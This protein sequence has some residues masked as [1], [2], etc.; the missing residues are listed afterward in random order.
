MRNEFANAFEFNQE[1]GIPESVCLR[2]L[3]NIGVDEVDKLRKYMGTPE[4]IG[5]PTT[6]REKDFE[7]E[8]LYA[9]DMSF[10]TEEDTDFVAF[11]FKNRTSLVTYFRKL[12][13][14]LCKMKLETFSVESYFAHIHDDKDLTR[15]GQLMIVIDNDGEN[16]LLSI[17]SDNKHVIMCPVRG[18]VIFLNSHEQHALLPK[19]GASPDFIKDMPM[20]LI[21]VQ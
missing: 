18:D 7:L 11:D 1:L 20:R 17:D 21:C 4:A 19:S 15:A 12:F 13:P 14:S 16:R 9:Y 8:K 2:V 5:W 3:C 6:M 10:L